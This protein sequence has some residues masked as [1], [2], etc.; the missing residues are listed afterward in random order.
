[1]T[2]KNVSGIS[3]TGIDRLILDLYDYS[4]KCNM[5]CNEIREMISS[6]KN[7]Y[8]TEDGNEFRKK[9][10]NYNLGTEKLNKNILSIVSDLNKV[11]S[12]YLKRD[13]KSADIFDT[14]VKGN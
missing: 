8:N 2:N 12:N 9:Y 5:L 14:S 7:Y 4:E 6:T 13:K 3:V 10:E 1:M 11:K